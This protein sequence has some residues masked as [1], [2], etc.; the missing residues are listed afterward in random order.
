MSNLISHTVGVN[1]IGLYFLWPVQRL[2]SIPVAKHSVYFYH[3][4][5]TSVFQMLP[6]QWS[7][8]CC[9]WLYVRGY[10][11]KKTDCA[12]VCARNAKSELLTPFIITHVQKASFRIPS[13]SWPK[14]G[15]SSY[16]THQM[17]QVIKFR[18]VLHTSWFSPLSH[19]NWTC[20]SYAN[21]G[22]ANQFPLTSL[23]CL[24]SNCC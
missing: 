16:T 22:K 9:K 20:T 18:P 1:H 10:F 17:L 11:I 19:I 23:S 7:S 8:G 24:S 5:D 4:A 15:S 13:Q 21:H 12:C 2:A 3:S 6:A 14:G